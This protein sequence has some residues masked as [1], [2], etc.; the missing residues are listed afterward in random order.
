MKWLPTL[1]AVAKEAAVVVGGAVLAAFII[2]QC[3][4]L[5]AWI[6]EQWDE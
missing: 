6:K 3:P 1:T 2:G 4:G 5:K